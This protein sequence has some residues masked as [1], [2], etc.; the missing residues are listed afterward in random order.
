MAFEDLDMA[1]EA[2]ASK[3]AV[4]LYETGYYEHVKRWLSEVVD[5]LQDEGL[6]SAE[7]LR[8]S[9]FQYCVND[10]VTEEIEDQ[11][12][13]LSYKVS[14]AIEKLELIQAIISKTEDYQFQSDDED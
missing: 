11:V 9:M 14:E 3:D 2:I 1:S 10:E 12:S 7:E 6:G 5:E 13:D 4:E 8:A